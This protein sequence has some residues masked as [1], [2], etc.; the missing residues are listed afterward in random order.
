[1]T[2]SEDKVVFLNVVAGLN[3][4][5]E[6]LRIVVIRE[7]LLLEDYYRLLAVCYL[8]SELS[9]L[10]VGVGAVSSFLSNSNLLVRMIHFNSDVSRIRACLVILN[11][12]LEGYK[13]AFACVC[14]GSLCRGCAVAE[15]LSCLCVSL[16]RCCLL[17][18][19][20]VE[21]VVVIIDYITRSVRYCNLIIGY[22][23]NSVRVKR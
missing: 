4:N 7:R 10:A 13:T 15:H 5:S 22:G 12:L 17:N 20:E 19:R 8:R 2:E 16:D 21:Y 23:V 3:L 1:M 9:V 6:A 11:N 14:L 18:Y